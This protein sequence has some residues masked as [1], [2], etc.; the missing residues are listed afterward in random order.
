VNDSLPLRAAHTTSAPASARP[1]A[2]ALPM[3]RDAPVTIAT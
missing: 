1:T 2:R 3:P